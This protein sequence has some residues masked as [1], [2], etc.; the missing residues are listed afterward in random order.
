[1]RAMPSITVALDAVE[2]GEIVDAKTIV[3]LQYVALREPAGVRAAT[4]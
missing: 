2:R 3:L 1:M 4:A